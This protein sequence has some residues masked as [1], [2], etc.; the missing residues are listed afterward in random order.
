MNTRRKA[1][2][3]TIATP[4][5]I[6]NGSTQGTYVPYWRPLRPGADQHEAVPS[7]M[8]KRLTYRDGRVET[9]A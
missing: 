5:E 2:R 7:R 9:L 1:A 4:R 3:Q 6:V 8:G